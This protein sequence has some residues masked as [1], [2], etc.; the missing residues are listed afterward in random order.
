[1]YFTKQN[2]RKY[3]SVVLFLHLSLQPFSNSYGD[4]FWQ[5]ALYKTHLFSQ[6]VIVKA[7][8]KIVLHG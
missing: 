4:F 8:S 7:S 1:M 5:L 2:K 6:T 3:K